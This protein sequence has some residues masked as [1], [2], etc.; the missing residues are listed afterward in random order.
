MR[1]RVHLLTEDVVHQGLEGRW[2][3][4]QAERHDQKFEEA[5]VCSEHCLGDIIGVHPDL[6]IAQAQ[7][8]LW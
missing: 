7:I 5:F 3:I 6:V 8:Q 2:H 4:G 1:V